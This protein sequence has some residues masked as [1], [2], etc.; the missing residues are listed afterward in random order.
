MNAITTTASAD[1][2]TGPICRLRTG[3]YFYFS[4]F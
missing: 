3:R 2:A 4:E 1:S